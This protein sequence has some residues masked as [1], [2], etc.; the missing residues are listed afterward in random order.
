MIYELLK[1]MVDFSAD[2]DMTLNIYTEKD[3]FIRSN[4]G[5]VL[6]GAGTG[7]VRTVMWVSG[8]RLYWR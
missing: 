2:V 8:L 7:T 5:T 6:V 1:V 3:R 4:K